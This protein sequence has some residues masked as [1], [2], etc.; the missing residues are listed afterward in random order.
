LNNNGNFID[1]ALLQRSLLAT[2]CIIFIIFSDQ[3]KN[4]ELIDFLEFKN[5]LG[6]C[7]TLGKVPYFFLPIFTV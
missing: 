2:T 6:I 3:Q 1:L 7:Y 5:A 4:A